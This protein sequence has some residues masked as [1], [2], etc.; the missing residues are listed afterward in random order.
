V[1]IF[2]ILT[3]STPAGHLF[4]VQ[5]TIF[6]S[7]PGRIIIKWSFPHWCGSTLGFPRGEAVAKIGS[8]QPILVTDEECGRKA[9]DF[10][11]VADLL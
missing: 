11:V 10:C 9:Y 5:I 2:Y 8:S 1:H 4:S 6:I 3:D 7:H